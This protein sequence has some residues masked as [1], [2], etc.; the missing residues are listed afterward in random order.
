MGGTNIYNREVDLIGSNV[1]RILSPGMGVFVNDDKRLADMD[2]RT[3]F[4]QDV[5]IWYR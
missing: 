3:V 1:E 5:R 4:L 2:Y